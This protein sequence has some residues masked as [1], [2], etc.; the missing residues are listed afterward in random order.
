MS[1]VKTCFGCGAPI[2]RGYPMITRTGRNVI[3]CERCKRMTMEEMLID[4]LRKAP[5]KDIQALLIQTHIQEYGLLSD[6]NGEI[7][8][9]ILMKGADDE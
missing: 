8:R 6:A 7:V 9:Q 2:R 3:L 1:E 4:A 5:N